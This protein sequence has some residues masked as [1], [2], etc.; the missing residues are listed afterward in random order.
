MPVMR[1][2]YPH[3]Y[4]R[5]VDH[6][7][8]PR[9]VHSKDETL[10]VISFKEDVKLSMLAWHIQRQHPQDY[11]VLLNMAEDELSEVAKEMSRVE[12]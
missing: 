4:M 8:G 11:N 7:P 12:D 1:V 3:A 10:P 6:L 9:D 5:A 2:G